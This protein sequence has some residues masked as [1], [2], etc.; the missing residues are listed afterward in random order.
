MSKQKNS[1]LNSDQDECL[2]ESKMRGRALH[3][4]RV[5]REDHSKEAF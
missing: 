2:E 5:V 4:L 3:F 1:L